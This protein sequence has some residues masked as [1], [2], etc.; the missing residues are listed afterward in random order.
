[1]NNYCKPGTNIPLDLDV[2]HSNNFV[3]Q[4]IKNLGPNI[5]EK[6]VAGICKA[7][8]ATR[9]IMDN[10]DASIG[11]AVASGSHGSGDSV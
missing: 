8:T 6:A 11:H 2:E 9:T 1:M 7:E 10:T 3:K 5:S 4:A